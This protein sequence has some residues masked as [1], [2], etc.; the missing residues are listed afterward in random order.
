MSEKKI[1]KKKVDTSK[2]DMYNDDVVFE[3]EDSEMEDA[4]M[5]DKIKK[6]REA[7]EQCRKENKENLLGWQRARADF[8]NA[9]K[10]NEQKMKD[11]FSFAKGQLIEELLPVVDSF[12]MAFSNKDAWEKV[13]KNW[14]VGVEYIYSQLLSV[15]ER[16]GVKEINPLGQTFNP[17]FHTSVETVA[18]EN[19]DDDEKVVEVMQ[20]GY[21]VN[22]R[23]LRPARVKVARYTDNPEN[24]SEDKT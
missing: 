22:G 18:A 19:K 4:A 16:N 15:L 9:K 23:V 13:D 12:E 24:D 3:D 20:K 1:K 7:L 14:R 10:E 5:K 21:E 6:L 2:N 8:V 17:Q 11:S